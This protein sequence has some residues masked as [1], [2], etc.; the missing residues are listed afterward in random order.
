MDDEKYMIEGRP[1]SELS[2]NWKCPVCGE[3]FNKYK[4]PVT[5]FKL[6]KAETNLGMI[7]KDY[8]IEVHCLCGFHY[9]MHSDLRM[10]IENYI[11][12]TCENCKYGHWDEERKGYI[13]DTEAMK[14][15]YIEEEDFKTKPQCSLGRYYSINDD[16]EGDWNE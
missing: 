16:F 13:C 7:P 12:A 2:P 10:G 5:I 9:W 3:S 14:Y 4:Q 1:T 8:G 15:G 11:L 6:P